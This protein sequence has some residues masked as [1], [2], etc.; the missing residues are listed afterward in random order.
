MYDFLFVINTNLPPILHRFRDIAVDRSEIAIFYYTPLVFNS[1]GGGLKHTTEYSVNFFYSEAATD[2][3][4]CLEAEKFI[5]VQTSAASAAALQFS[6]MR[7]R[8]TGGRRLFC[9][10]I[11]T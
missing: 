3:S 1:P 5:K 8:D 6:N 4:R 11:S 10:L 7:H 2:S 9:Q